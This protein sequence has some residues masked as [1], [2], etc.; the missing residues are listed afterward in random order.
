M[1]NNDNATCNK[2]CSY[3]KKTTAA[4]G[5][6]GERSIMSD[7]DIGF[8]VTVLQR[9]AGY[10]DAREWSDEEKEQRGFN[11]E[12]FCGTLGVFGLDNKPPYMSKG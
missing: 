2:L 1:N 3:Y 6:L 12:D 8:M 11:K 4:C 9:M 5:G 10:S 7:S